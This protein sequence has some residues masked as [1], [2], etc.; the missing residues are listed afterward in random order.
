[1]GSLSFYV[2]LAGVALQDIFP[3]PFALSNPIFFCPA[4]VDAGMAQVRLRHCHLPP[5]AAVPWW[6]SCDE[7][8]GGCMRRLR[9]QTNTAVASTTTSRQ[10]AAEREANGEAGARVLCSGIIIGASPQLLA[11]SLHQGQKVWAVR[12]SPERGSVDATVAIREAVRSQ[13]GRV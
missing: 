6:M 8:V 11:S 7:P 2:L 5:P 4:D 1:M 10:R 9:C 12:D 3:A 13:K